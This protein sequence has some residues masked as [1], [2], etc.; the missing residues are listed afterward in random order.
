MQVIQEQARANRTVIITARE[1]DG[2]SETREIEPY[3]IRPG[4]NCKGPRLYGFCLMRGET[5]SWTIGNITGAKATGRIF[6]PRWPV[7]L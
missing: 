2:T 5:R 1:S 6:S 3:S 7:E 4:A